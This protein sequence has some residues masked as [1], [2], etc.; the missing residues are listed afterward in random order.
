MLL[1][2]FEV[3]D[4]LRMIQNFPLFPIT[5]IAVYLSGGLNEGQESLTGQRDSV[6]C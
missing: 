4:W 5:L 2:S 6:Y 3:F 1:I